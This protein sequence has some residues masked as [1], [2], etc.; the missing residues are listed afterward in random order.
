MYLYRF[1]LFH[2]NVR[3]HTLTESYREVSIDRNRFEAL[4]PPWPLIR[5]P[6]IAPRIYGVIHH[7]DPGCN[8][9]QSLGCDDGPIPATAGSILAWCTASAVAGYIATFCTP[10]SPPFWT[11]VA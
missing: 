8:S 5:I 2:R 1:S 10:V 9:N 11:L 4:L 6:F 7:V 3:E